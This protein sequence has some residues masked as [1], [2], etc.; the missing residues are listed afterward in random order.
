MDAVRFF[1]GDV[2]TEV[3]KSTWP[4]RQELFEST[5]VVI[6]SVMLLSLFVGVSDK[7]LITMLRLLIPSSGN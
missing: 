7:L 4:S 2:I 5:I 1:V 6:V 3:K